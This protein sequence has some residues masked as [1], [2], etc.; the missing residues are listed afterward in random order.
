MAEK[1]KSNRTK[2]A[3]V[4]R[5]AE[6]VI[7]KRQHITELTENVPSCNYCVATIVARPLEQGRSMQGRSRLQLLCRYNSC[8]AAGARP[9][10]ARPF[11]ARPT[12]ARPFDGDDDFYLLNKNNNNSI[13]S[14]PIF[15]SDLVVWGYRDP[16]M[17]SLFLHVIK[18]I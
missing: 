14:S 11:D 4:A 15:R 6:I 1:L 7:K 2:L 3:A 8:K 18:L 13:S 10:D 5:S 17:S 9:F 16:A 12:V